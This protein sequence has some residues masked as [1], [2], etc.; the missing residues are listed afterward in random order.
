VANPVYK[1]CE[2]F[3][4][5]SAASRTYF[6]ISPLGSSSY[7]GVQATE[8]FE[9]E[10]TSAGESFRKSVT[11]MAELVAVVRDVFGRNI[12]AKKLIDKVYAKMQQQDAAAKKANTLEVI[13]GYKEAITKLEATL[14]D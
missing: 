3:A 13:K 5:K 10:L 2:E 1:T 7:E 14:E 4:A 9:V 12:A 11:G 8:V 6:T